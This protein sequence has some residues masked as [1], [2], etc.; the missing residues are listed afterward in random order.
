LII[1]RNRGK[2]MTIPT[3]CMDVDF[4][5]QILLATKM[6]AP[7]VSSESLDELQNVL[8]IGT[9]NTANAS[10]T[11]L[12]EDELARRYCPTAYIPLENGRLLRNNSLKVV[13]QLASGGLS[14]LYLCQ[15]DNKE[16]VVLKEAVVPESSAEDLKEK[17]AELFEREGKLLVKLNH[18]GIV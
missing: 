2:K 11:D 14:A 10:Y 15:Q 4:V 18:P 7:S 13:N 3:R 5:E 6:W 8:R 12:W 9:R 17:A 16:L 1:S